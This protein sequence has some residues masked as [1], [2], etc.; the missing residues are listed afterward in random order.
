MYNTFSSSFLYKKFNCSDTKR[1]RER[2]REK[3]EWKKE[4]LREIN[5]GAGTKTAL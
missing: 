1:E 4:V 3:Y 2:E 5:K